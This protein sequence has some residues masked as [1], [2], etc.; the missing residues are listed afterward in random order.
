MGVGRTH[1]LML[2]AIVASV[3][4]VAEVVPGAPGRHRAAAAVP[5]R[6]SSRRRGRARTA[7]GGIHRIRH[8]IV[9]MQ[10]N[11]SFDSYFGTFPGAD[12]L[13]MRDGHPTVCVPDEATATCDKPFHDPRLRNGGGPHGYRSAL[14]DIDHG[15]LNGFVATA[16]AARHTCLY[17]EDP[18]CEMRVDP[19]VM[20][21][22]DAREIPNY[23][24]LARRYV[25]ADHL[26][27]SDSSWSLPAHL[28]M[29]SE[30][31]ARCSTPFDAAS[32]VGDQGY[33]VADPGQ[34]SGQVPGEY[35]WTDLTYLLHRA[36]VSWRYYVHAGRQPDCTDDEALT[37]HAPRQSA[38]TPGIWNPL[39]W[40]ATVYEDHQLGDIVPT[41]NFFAAARA[42][43]LPA[44]SWVI[45]DDAHSE[46]PPASIRAGQ[47]Y[48]TSVIDAAMRS[49]DW[50]H[51]AIFLAWDDWGG[52]YDHVRPPR[53]DREG[54]GLRV[55][56][57]IISPYA[58]HGV[59]DHEV[60]S[61]DSFNRFIEDDFLHGERLD[62]ATD[63]RP[64][65]RPDARDARAGLSSLLGAFDFHQR[66]RPPQPLPLHPRPGRAAHLQVRAGRAQARGRDVVV[67]MRCNDRCQVLASGAA[68][69]RASLPSGRWW[70]VRLTRVSRRPGAVVRLR[71]DGRLGPRRRLHRPVA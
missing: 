36:H 22:H 62:P 43:R 65:P 18:A 20:G 11:R 61:F 55:P 71:V 42:G 29:V 39:P 28:Y 16:R 25:L 14:T 10:E 67:A 17:A 9:I 35:A 52:F 32:C 60:A 51:T 6:G 56:G 31:S 69:G 41:D 30:W 38:T 27:E 33:D 44:V 24:R 26:F 23:W 58:R 7:G 13:P 15:R 12:G 64:D 4:L 53:I 46:H 21:W 2:A 1:L 54:Y 59:V 3:I 5:R 19:D 63:G 70:T 47:R 49:P 8:V 50:P 68:R 34:V 40:F 45:P 66:P 57:I 37:C 48:V